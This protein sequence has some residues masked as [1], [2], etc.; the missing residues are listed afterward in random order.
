MQVTHLHLPGQ[1]VN[2]M[3]SYTGKTVKA[4]GSLVATQD[5]STASVVGLEVLSSHGIIGHAVARL[6][7]FR[8]GMTLSFNLAATVQGT[9]GRCY[10]SW[11]R[12]GTTPSV[13]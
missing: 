13:S 3:C 4:V 8:T 11:G 6:K 1:V 2:A 5:Y 9:P 7:P 12:L 10:V